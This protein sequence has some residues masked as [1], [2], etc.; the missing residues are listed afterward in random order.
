MNTNDR[1]YYDREQ[2]ENLFAGIGQNLEM[3]VRALLIGGGA[4]C[5]KGNKASTKDVDNRPEREHIDHS[6]LRPG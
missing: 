3:G 4:M 1:T 6:G 2:I 5:L